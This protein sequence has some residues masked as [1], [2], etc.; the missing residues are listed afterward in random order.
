MCERRAAGDS[1]EHASAGRVQARSRTVTDL[2][3][4]VPMSWRGVFPRRR[5]VRGAAGSF[6]LLLAIEFPR[7]ITFSMAAAPSAIKS[8]VQS[9][10]GERD[11]F[12]V[13]RPFAGRTSG[14][15]GLGR[16]GARCRA[17]PPFAPEI[18]ASGMA[19]VLPW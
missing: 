1:R 3:G 18:R 14:V 10:L 8:M 9:G 4:A 11:P 19:Y 2:A 6:D 17:N 15:C 7:G 16:S 5:A 13:G 12:G